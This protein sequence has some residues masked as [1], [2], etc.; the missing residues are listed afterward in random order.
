MLRAVCSIS[1]ARLRGLTQSTTRPVRMLRLRQTPSTPLL[2]FSLRAESKNQHQPC[3]SHG[4]SQQMPVFSQQP[5]CLF[6]LFFRG[7]SGPEGWPK[8]QGGPRRLQR[9]Q[10]LIRPRSPP[11]SVFFFH[12]WERWLAGQDGGFNSGAPTQPAAPPFPPLGCPLSAAPSL[13]VA[14]TQPFV[15]YIEISSV[16]SSKR[17]HHC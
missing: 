10:P 8:G 7:K 13:P 3:C 17:F 11:L 5:G 6:R 15:S 2:I 4:D 1:T 12:C 9:F 14:R 16:F